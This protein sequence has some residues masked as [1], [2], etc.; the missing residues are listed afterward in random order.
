MHAR[1]GDAHLLPERCILALARQ[2]SCGPFFAFRVSVICVVLMLIGGPAEPRCCL[3]R[4]MDPNSN[5]DSL[6]RNSRSQ[7]AVPFS[8]V[9]ARL[10]FVRLEFLSYQIHSFPSSLICIVRQRSDACVMQGDVSKPQACLGA[11]RPAECF[12][13]TRQRCRLS[14]RVSTVGI[15]TWQMSR[16]SEPPDEHIHSTT[17]G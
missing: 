16:A 2:M 8:N 12:C 7:G 17:Q 6:V 10:G 3:S 14:G 4:Q 9:V 13:R 1:A 15:N 11:L 5:V